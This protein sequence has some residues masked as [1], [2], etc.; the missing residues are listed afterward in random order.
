MARRSSSAFKSQSSPND[1]TIKALQISLA[2]PEYVRSLSK[3]E[4]TSFETINYKSL[5]PEKGGL[6]CE[7]IFGP[8]KDYECSCGKYKQV[9]YKGKK[10]EK[11]KVYITQSLVRRDW[12]GHIELA[13]PVAHIWMIKEL[14][15]PAKISLILGIKYKH[16]EE[17]VYF[18]NYIVLDPGH[19]QVEG[20][21]LFDP[22]EI[23]DVSNSKSS[24][25]SLAKL[26]TLLRTIYETIQKENPESYLT[27]LNY[28]QGRAYYK[29]LSNSNLPFSIMDMF[30]YIEKH[31]G[32][33]VGIGAEAIYELLK[34]VDLESLEYK[35]TQELNVNFPS[36]LNYADPKVRKILSRLQVI[37]WFKESKNRPEWMI[38]KVIPV[39]P[40]NLRPII[41]LSG[42]RFTSSDINTFYRRIIVR[43]DRLARILN[44]NVAHIISNNEKRMLQE[45]VDSLIDNSSRKKPLTAR[46]RHPLKSITDHL[47]GKQGLFRQNLLGKRVDYS[48]RS[49]IVVGS[50]L[51]MYQVGLPILMILSL[52]K[53]F[54]IRDLIRKVDDN[55]VECVPI[56]ANI[57]TASK[58]IMEQS[59]EIWPVVHKVIKERPVLLNR[60]PTLHRLS[61]QAFEPILV[62]GKAICLH[63]LVT[64][65]FNADF[66]GDQMAVHLPLSAEAVHEARSMLL[67]PW[68][69]LGP[70]DGKPIVTPSQDM[71][72]GI[73]HLTTEDKEAIGSGSLFATPDEVVHAYQLG[74]VDLSSIIAIGTSGFPKKR[75]PK[76][77]ILI[78]T[79]GKIIF[80]SR[81]PEDYKFINQSE[82]MW[83]S[84]N[85]ILD[86]GVSRLDYINAY[87]E[88][89]PFAKSVI[90]RLIEDLYDNYSCQDLAPVLD[91]IKDMGFEYSTKSCTT[92]SAFD[93]PKFSDKQSLLEEADKLVEQQKSFFRKGLVTDDEKY[94]NVIAI[95]SSV[96]DKVSD[97][98]KNALKSKEFQSNPIVIM[99]RSGARGNVSNFIQLSGMRGLMNKSYNYD[100]N[101]NTKVVRD[102][103]EVPIKHS[104]IEGLT[105]IE[106]FNSSYGA[107]KGMTDTAMKT[108]KSG[109]TTRKLVD[110]AQEV[111]VK[112]EDCGSNK[113]LIVEELRDKEHSMPIKTLKDRIVFKCAHIDILHPE[114][115]EVIVGAN[116]VITKEAAD[117]IVAAGITKV[118]VRSVLHCR[119]KQGICQKCFG[120]DLT[121]KQMIDVGTT[122][123]VIAAQS[124][125]EP[126]VQLTMRTF[127]SGGVAGESNI[128]QGFE[129]LRQLFEIVAPKKWETSVISEITGTVENIEIRD[130]ERVVTVSS[131]INRREYNCDLNL[132]ILVKK[133]QK[134]NFGDRICDGSVDLKKLLEVSGV[135]AVRQYIVQEIWKVYWIQGIDVS[136][137]YIEIIVRQLTSR[138]KVLSPN[139][140][141]WAMGEVVDYSSFVD[142]CAKLLLDGK[143]PPIATS[144][145]FGLEEVPE[146]T[147][148]F[149]A[150]ASFQ[151]TKKI[152]TDACVRGQIDY[153]NSLKENIM[154]GNLIPAGTG[155]KSADEVISDERS[156]RNVFNY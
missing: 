102:I 63:P 138:L 21:T 4:V 55:G 88:K 91:S 93:V 108:A 58:M 134:I 146:K 45:A 145:I 89:E 16:V 65:A 9:K 153:L 106:Y 23:I 2:S 129:R 47:K 64:T 18:V 77:G 19:L 142:E 113:G 33:K 82:G 112:V 38:L 154:V 52:F 156:N 59:D 12:M 10:C 50:E 110:A 26:R 67:A 3:G 14:P 39:I 43:N 116:E 117:K 74:K 133:G 22:L 80:N 97:H 109:Y 72:L 57:K 132:P 98:I 7:S 37:R 81:L 51:K 152:L 143:T 122:I 79:V 126:A 29:A 103:I 68:Q 5:R 31:T 139:D 25:A 28:Q 71:V 96:K 69:I 118:Q 76:S 121:T 27:D 87:Q 135:E 125:G 104:F 15:L 90:G 136:E 36:G 24:I 120:Y 123:G 107:R 144:I 119:L 53:P 41:Q 84:E 149:L 32:L 35:L 73:Y 66:D 17:V 62:E 151:D 114:T 94:K 49:V 70:K 127:H 115:G 147:N 140:S 6:F 85:D 13:C 30:E 131:D 124:I 60:A 34:K 148:S 20:K 99:A 100:Q 130:D 141:K 83:V 150:A 95:W 11:C 101:T 8:I 86:Y 54:I 56:A 137:K 40:P 111:I 44:L 128:S 42:G 78:T 75:F 1:F 92:I 155:L 48:G 105:V 61:I 46:D